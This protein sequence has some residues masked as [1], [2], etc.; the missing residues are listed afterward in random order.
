MT[1][2]PELWRPMPEYEDRYEIS[3]LG[4]VRHLPRRKDDVQKN[5]KP[6]FNKGY[7]YIHIRTSGI[8]KSI[9][10]HRSVLRAPE[11]RRMFSGWSAHGICEMWSKRVG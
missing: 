2:K 11:A 5:L 4:N 1:N 9:P 7:P 10:I 8:L 6:Y 3:D